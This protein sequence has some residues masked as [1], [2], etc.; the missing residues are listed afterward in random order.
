[1]K[2]RIVETLGIACGLCREAIIF[3]ERHD[4]D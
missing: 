4:H 1:M 3:F 2:V